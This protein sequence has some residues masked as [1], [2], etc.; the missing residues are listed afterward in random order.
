[1]HLLSD[2][3]LAILWFFFNKKYSNKK[4]WNEDI[5]TVSKRWKE[6]MLRANST[7][8]QYPWKILSGQAK[9]TKLRKTE[10]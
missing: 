5:V 1:M 2:V 8:R 9:K 10:I 7:Y 3:L 4:C 6:E